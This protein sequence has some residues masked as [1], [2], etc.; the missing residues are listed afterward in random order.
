[1]STPRWPRIAAVLAVVLLTLSGAAEAAEWGHYED[2]RFGFAIDVP[3]GFAAAD[4]AGDGAAFATPVARLRVFGGTVLSGDF[5]GAVRQRQQTA[6]GQ[7]WTITDQMTAPNGATFSARKGAHLL[8]SRMIPLCGGQQFAMF[9]FDYFVA[10]MTKLEP[11]IGRLAQSLKAA[12]ACSA[13]G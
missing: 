1:V 8:F 10:D 12:R 4:E 13:N 9:E 2:A 6:A 11:V 3:P 7:G 5:E